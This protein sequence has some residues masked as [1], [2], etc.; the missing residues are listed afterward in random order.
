MDEMFDKF[1]RHANEQEKRMFEMEE[2][3]FKMEQDAEKRREE[4]EEARRREDREHELR[5]IQMFL[6][7]TPSQQ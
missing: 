6:N 2:K 1:I 7:R 4:R 5:V 3:R